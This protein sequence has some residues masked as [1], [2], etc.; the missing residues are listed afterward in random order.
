M[1]G[2]AARSDSAVTE[3]ADDAQAQ[4]AGRRGGHAA[5]WARARG[6]RGL[7]RG[8]VEAAERGEGRWARWADWAAGKRERADRAGRP[9]P[10]WEKGWARWAG[11]GFSYSLLPVLFLNPTQLFEFKFK[12]EFNPSTQTIKTMHQHECTNKLN[13]R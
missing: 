7:G 6:V 12:F 4:L 3:N 10:A 8:A 9:G 1:T 13:L 5:R 11:L 2:G